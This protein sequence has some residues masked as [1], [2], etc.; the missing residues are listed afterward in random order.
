MVKEREKLSI[1]MRVSAW[2]FMGE[3][4]WDALV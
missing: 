4:A 2:D 1:I 3:R